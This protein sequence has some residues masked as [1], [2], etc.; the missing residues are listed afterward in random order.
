MSDDTQTQQEGKGPERIYNPSYALF[1]LLTS[2]AENQATV[3]AWQ[4]IR[5]R[6]DEV[7][8]PRRIATSTAGNAL[9]VNKPVMTADILHQIHATVSRAMV[10]SRASV[11]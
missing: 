2:N 8:L 9:F 3:D 1:F 4:R 6:K 11:G 5:Q 7:E 10:L